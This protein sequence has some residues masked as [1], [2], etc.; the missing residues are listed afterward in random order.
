MVKDHGDNQ[1]GNPLP[2]QVCIYVCM[3]KLMDGW[4]MKE[5]RTECMG[6]FLHIIESLLQGK[7]TSH[8]TAL[9]L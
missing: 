2:P 5:G 3:Y 4:T 6:F 1:R 7:T 8:P 9:S